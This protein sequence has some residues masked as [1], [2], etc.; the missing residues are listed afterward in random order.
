MA[1]SPSGCVLPQ[2][3]LLFLQELAH[4]TVESFKVQAEGLGVEVIAELDCVEGEA[5]YRQRHCAWGS[6]MEE[7]A[8]PGEGGPLEQPTF[9]A[10]IP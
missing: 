9:T 5:C 7:W 6:L 8:G 1:A 2:Y 4:L 3:S 10:K